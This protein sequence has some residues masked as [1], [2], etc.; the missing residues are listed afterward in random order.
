M[1]TRYYEDEKFIN[2]DLSEDSDGFVFQTIAKELEDAF[3]IKWK[4]QATGLDQRY[5]D[6]EMN[7]IILTLHLEHYIGICVFADKNETNM[8][9]AEDALKVIEKHFKIWNPTA[10][11]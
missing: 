11:S 2:V 7:N 9:K 8:E 1:N 4:T 10:K 5:W 6:F 3:H